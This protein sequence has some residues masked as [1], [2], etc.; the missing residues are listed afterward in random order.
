MR[1]LRHFLSLINARSGGQK[2]LAVFFPD[3]AARVGKRVGCDAQ[4]V[5]S[6]I[7]NQPDGAVPL[8]GNALI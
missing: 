6:H 8:D 7:G 1:V 2:I 3:E 4:G 5:G